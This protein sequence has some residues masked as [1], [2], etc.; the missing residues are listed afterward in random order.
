MQYRGGRY[1]FIVAERNELDYK[2]DT[3]LNLLGSEG[4][5]T[6]RL[7]QEA[8]TVRRRVMGDEI[9]IRGIVEFSNICVNN[10]L[11]CGIRAS[12]KKVSRYS[13]PAEEIIE[14]AVS[15]EQNGLSTIVLQSG[16]TPGMR[17]EELGT[18]IRKIKQV[19]CPGRDRFRWKSIPR[20]VSLLE[21][22][23]NG[24]LFPPF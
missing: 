19:T 4:Q 10:C 12:N 9:Y 11:Y 20:N 2:K 17:D 18:I 7:Y 14:T 22:M 24:P 8:D 13:M 21:G 6:E 1:I 23:R 15:M 5:S 3:A 16:E